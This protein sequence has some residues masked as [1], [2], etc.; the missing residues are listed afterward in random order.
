MY[1]GQGL[2]HYKLAPAI[3]PGK[4]WEGALGCLIG[5]VVT[6]GLAAHFLL[7]QLP[8]WQ[9]LLLGVVISAAAQVSDLSE[10]LIKRYAGVKDSGELIPG[11]GGMLDRLDSLLFAAPLLLYTLH[12]CL[13]ASTP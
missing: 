11:H 6:A 8:L 12:L 13:P 9:H 7:P 5:G 4:T 10:S 2:G 3:S 1:V